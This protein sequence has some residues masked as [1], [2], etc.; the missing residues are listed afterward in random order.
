[1]VLAVPITGEFSRGAA[2]RRPTPRDGAA[3]AGSDADG[4]YEE[5]D[6]ESRGDFDHLRPLADP[7]DQLSLSRQRSIGAPK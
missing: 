1:M 4:E 6:P 2:P 5:G 3:H 7:L